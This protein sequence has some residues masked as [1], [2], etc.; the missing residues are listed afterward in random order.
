AQSLRIEFACQGDGIAVLALTREEL[1]YAL[2]L[3][4]RVAECGLDVGESMQDGALVLDLRLIEPRF[5]NFDVGSNAPRGE[6][7]QAQGRSQREEVPYTQPE[8]RGFRGLPP[9]QTGEHQ[10]RVEIRTG[11]AHAGRCGCDLSL[12]TTQVGAPAQ[13]IRRNSD[14]KR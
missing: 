14:R 9:R 6:Y 7:R 8:V 13:E 2:L 3:T 4:A 11:H 1:F 10:L 12:R 5:L